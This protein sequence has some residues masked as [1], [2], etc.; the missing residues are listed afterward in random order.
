MKSQVL[1]LPLA[2]LLITSKI[3][4]FI[5][6]DYIDQS[7]LTIKDKFV[8]YFGKLAFYAF[9][10]GDDGAVETPGRLLVLLSA[11]MG[12]RFHYMSIFS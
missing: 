1:I 3:S 9:F 4:P 12:M 8:G 2:C 10:R 11:C 7:R 6:W 5:K